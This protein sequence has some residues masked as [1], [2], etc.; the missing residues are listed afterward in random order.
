MDR[1]ITIS[2]NAKS[3]IIEF[4]NVPP[5]KISVIYPAP[6]FDSRDANP[7][8]AKKTI[9]QKYTLGEEY[10]LYIGQIGLKKNLNTLIKAYKIIKEKRPDAPPLILVGPRYHLSDAG[11]IF[12]MI[13]RFNL[14][15]CIHYLGPVEKHQLY[16][17]LSKALFLLFPSVHEGFGIPLVE[18]MQQGIPVIASNTSVMPEVLNNA[19]VLVNEFLSPSAWADK[20]IQL[21][22]DPE[23]RN[24]LSIQGSNR[25]KNFSWKTSAEKLI[26]I[27]EELL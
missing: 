13:D 10:I 16:E 12:D 5:E 17:I 20:I 19:G 25:A 15:E 8:Q 23:L 4:L 3:E 11:E 24:Q 26:H 9:R 18:A 7:D 6:Q 1:I 2:E 14:N 22:D 21:Y 27:Y